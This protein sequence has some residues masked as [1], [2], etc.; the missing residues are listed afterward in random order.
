MTAKPNLGGTGARQGGPALQPVVLLLGASKP[1]DLAGLVQGPESEGNEPAER[2]GVGGREVSAVSPGHELKHGER[3][4][5]EEMVV[6]RHSAARELERQR[7]L[8]SH[9]T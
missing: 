5:R 3:F 1:R 8:R 7:A 6:Q 2:N 9:L 4:E